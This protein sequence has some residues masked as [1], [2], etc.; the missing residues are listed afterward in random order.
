M[1]VEEGTQA[2]DIGVISF[3]KGQLRV[4]AIKMDK[5][6]NPNQV[7]ETYTVDGFQG[8]DS[9][10]IILDIVAAAVIRHLHGKEVAHGVTQHVR[11][12]NRLL[13]AATR[14]KYGMIVCCSIK[15]L[16]QAYNPEASAGTTGEALVSMMQNADQRKLIADDYEEDD[17]PVL[18]GQLPTDIKARMQAQETFRQRARDV[19]YLADMRNKAL[20]RFKPRTETDKPRAYRGEEGKPTSYP[21]GTDTDPN[22]GPNAKEIEQADHPD[23]PGPGIRPEDVDDTTK[24]VPKA[25]PKKG[26]SR[27]QQFVS[28][29]LDPATGQPDLARPQYRGGRQGGRPRGQGHGTGGVPRGDWRGGHGGGPRGGP[30][31]TGAPG[32]RGQGGSSSGQSGGS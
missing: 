5:D 25:Q 16:F 12:P 2:K 9:P 7:V 1:C 27:Q 19:S 11:N 14:G 24:R 8:S 22:V 30:R 13:V 28:Y 21:E 29:P 15:P 10:V 31:G 32:G 26:G 20:R 23:G 3:Y 6:G 18:Q 4:L 17:N